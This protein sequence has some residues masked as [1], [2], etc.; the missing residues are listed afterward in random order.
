M[1][2]DAMVVKSIIIAGAAGLKQELV[3]SDLL[4]ARMKSRVVKI[5]DVAYGGRQGL[6]EAIES[7]RNL[8]ADA[9]TNEVVDRLASWQDG[10]AR[11]NPLMI[12]GRREIEWALRAGAVATLF[13]TDPDDPLSGVDTTIEI[14]IVP[15]V[16]ANTR[17][18]RVGFGGVGAILRF[19]I[20]IPDDLDE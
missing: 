15:D 8:I 16:D 10:L 5:I 2:G 4:D 14:V 17:Q 12:H 6:A 13:V 1:N 3:D 18:F 20:E 11:D 9:A 7:T 19:P